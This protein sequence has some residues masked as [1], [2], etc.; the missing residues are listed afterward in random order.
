MQKCT[1]IRQ[2]L[3]ILEHC[4]TYEYIRAR[5]M[6]GFSVITDIKKKYKKMRI[7]L[8]KFKLMSPEEIKQKFYPTACRRKSKP[9][10][11]IKE[12]YMKITV[13]QHTTLFEQRIEYKEKYSDGYAYTQFKKHFTD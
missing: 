1:T 10:P 4:I 11:D 7:S 5:C 13:S 2:I 12:V 6:V 8:N 9:F 3:E